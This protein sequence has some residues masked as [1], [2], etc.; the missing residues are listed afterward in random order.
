MK[1]GTCGHTP[2]VRAVMIDGKN[3]IRVEDRPTGTQMAIG[4]IETVSRVDEQVKVDISHT[5][6]DESRKQKLHALF[7]FGGLFSEKPGLTHVW[8]HEIDTGDNP[9]VASMPYRYDRV[10]QKMIDYHVNKMLEEGTIIP[11]QS[12]Y[13]SPVELCSKNN[14]QS[15]ESPEASRFATDCRKLNKITKYPRYP[16]P[17][18]EDITKNIPN[19][20]V[21]S[22]L[23]LR[24][25]YFQLAVIPIEGHP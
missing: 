10:K 21:M 15:P 22:T 5:N 14:G 8:Y 2:M 18:I 4:T 11:I 23:D 13:A 25:G 16:L 24:S 1:N 20:K 12:L 9:P 7:S 6:L 3:R 17:L 19:I